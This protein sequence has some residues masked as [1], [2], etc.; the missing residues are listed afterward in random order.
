MNLTRGI[1]IVLLTGLG[2]G[3]TFT[4]SGGQSG[5]SV[6]P[7][8]VRGNVPGEWRYWGGDAWSTR[9]SPLDQINASNFGKLKVAWQWNA[10]RVRP[11]RV[12]PDDAALCQRPTVHGRHDA[13]D[14]RRDRSRERRDA[15]DVADGRR[16]PLAESAASVRRPRPGLLDRRRERAR[17]RR[18]ARLPPRV[19]R[20]EDGPARSQVRQERH[21]RPDGRTRISA[22]APR[23]GRCRAA[24]HQRRGAGAEG[25]GPARRGTRR[26]RPAPTARS[27]SIPR[28]ARLA[29][30][31]RP[32]S[33]TTSSSSATRT[34]TAT[35]P[36][37]LRNLPSYIRGFDVRTGKQLW[38]FNLVP[39][40]GEFGADT[41]V[42]G[43]KPGTPG[44][45]KSECLGDVLSRS[46]ARAWSTSPSACR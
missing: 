10:E 21:R 29:S 16:H 39:E 44:V 41:W 31:V 38:K 23:R 19:A 7:A 32:S 4:V 46:G 1:A 35:I 34:S 20:R 24:R 11:G 33:S 28:S 13:P 27:A 26:R 18:D 8:L 15:L 6:K 17:H 3:G 12:L 42:N 30:A 2:V 22:R 43:T 36:I 5:A 14:C 9:Y 45:G 25:A 40:P 37:R